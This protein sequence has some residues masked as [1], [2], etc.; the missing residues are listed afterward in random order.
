MV[1][2]FHILSRSF[3]LLLIFAKQ[4]RFWLPEPSYFRNF[5]ILNLM[6]DLLR[7]LSVWDGFIFDFL[8]V[9]LLF[10]VQ[11]L[12]PGSEFRRYLNNSLCNHEIVRHIRNLILNQSND[13]CVNCKIY[14][15]I[16]FLFVVI[17]SLPFQLQNSCL[18]FFSR[19]C[20]IVY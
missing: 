17:V 7:K 18:L 15:R 4:H 3:L 12:I 9:E 5:S 10:C 16:L 8:V 11:L 13:T 1:G 14:A 19:L 6:S 20:F 2:G